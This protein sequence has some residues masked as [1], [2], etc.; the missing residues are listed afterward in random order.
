VEANKAGISLA[1]PIPYEH[2]LE[3]MKAFKPGNT[4]SLS[5]WEDDFAPI[6]KMVSRL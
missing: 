3:Q 1:I 4:I 5:Y 2:L 6:L